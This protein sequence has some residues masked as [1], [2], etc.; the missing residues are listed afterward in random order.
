VR[1]ILRKLR[2]GDNAVCNIRVP[3]VFVQGSTT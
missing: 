3:A 1:V 2:D